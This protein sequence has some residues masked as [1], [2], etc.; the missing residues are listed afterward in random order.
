M[1]AVDPYGWGIQLRVLR[2][3]TNLVRYERSVQ[4]WQDEIMPDLLE[5]VAR[6]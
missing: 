6:G 4:Q 3:P 5:A 2:S 1:D